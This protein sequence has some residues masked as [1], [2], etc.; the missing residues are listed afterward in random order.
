VLQA[1]YKQGYKGNHGATNPAM[2]PYSDQRVNA[3]AGVMKR[4]LRAKWLGNAV[5]ASMSHAMKVPASTTFRPE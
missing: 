2:A 1:I 5:F 4:E 3:K